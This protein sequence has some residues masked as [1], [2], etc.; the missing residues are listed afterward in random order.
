MQSDIDER[1]SLAKLDQYMQ[2]TLT[3]HSVTSTFLDDVVHD[4]TPDSFAASIIST[5][6]SLTDFDAIYIRGPKMRLRSEL[7][8]YVSRFCAV[9]KIRCINDYSLYYPGTKVAQ[10][11]VF[12]EE[13]APFLDTIYTVEN[14]RLIAAAENR[15]G[16]PYILKTTA[17][18]HGDAN[19]LIKSR[20]DAET[21]ISQD[22]GVD[23][24][25]QQ[26]CENDR[27]YRVLV[28][29][30]ESLIFARKGASDSH[31]N[32]TSKGA[33]AELA[34]SGEV[35]VELVEKSRQIAARLGLALAGADVMPKLGTDEFYFLEINSQPQF[36][37]GAFL[38][39]KQQIIRSLFSE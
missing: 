1:E 35:P 13:A 3:D 14:D 6:Q 7:A 34:V 39:E 10:A 30:S 19:Y 8:F 5:G 28:A 25:A 16:Y 2:Q 29:P 21:A 33:E 26:F 27:D 11:I 23:F 15:L 38:D 24:L 17:G 36:R 31:L 12:Y 18:S 22:V 37:T 4:I 20:S 9:N 32:N